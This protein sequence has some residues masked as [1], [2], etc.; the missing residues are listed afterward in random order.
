M[1]DATS[2]VE[3][4][5]GEAGRTGA[6]S[7]G[8]ISVSARSECV[9]LVRY[10]A[11]ARAAA[12]VDEEAVALPTPASVDDVLSAIRTSRGPELVRILSACSFL[13]DGVAVHDHAMPVRD[14]GALD[15]LPP[16]AGG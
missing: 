4:T 14:G 10:F 15:V 2:I 3:N 7:V 9:V 8:A 5:T 16:F 6:V 12:R 13:L 1:T 11:G